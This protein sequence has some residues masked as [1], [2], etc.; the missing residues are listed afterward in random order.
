MPVT[1]ISQNKLMLSPSKYHP[2]SYYGILQKKRDIIK[3]SIQT[4]N[5]YNQSKFYQL[6]E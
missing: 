3:D 4:L 2:T 5:L 6:N 1:P